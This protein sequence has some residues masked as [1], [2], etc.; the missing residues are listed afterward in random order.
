M[1]DQLFKELKELEKD[2]AGEEEVETEEQQG[3]LP[4]ELLEMIEQD[5][6]D[7][8]D[9]DNDVSSSDSSDDDDEDDD[10]ELYRELARI[11][12]ERE[13]ERLEKEAEK[14]QE[15]QERMEMDALEGNP[16]LQGQ[17]SFGVKRRWDSDVIFRNQA[18]GD[19]QPKKRFINDLTRSDFHRKFMSKYVK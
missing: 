15:E 13:K 8:D 4:E 2:T 19:V 10:E 14:A 3:G 16:L 5:K 1:K 9:D 7:T 17:A 18:K 12:A 11:K 6:D